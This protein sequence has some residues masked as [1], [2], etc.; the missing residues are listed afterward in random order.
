MVDTTDTTDDSAASTTAGSGGR[1]RGRPRDPEVERCILSAAADVFTDGGFEKFSVEA[2]AT[3]AG[4]AKASIYRRY[5][6]R[7]DLIVAMCQECTPSAA[8]PI[9]NGDLRSDLVEFLEFLRE[10]LS[11]T[12]QSGRLMPALLSAAKEYTE[13]RE[14]A[15]KFTASRRRRIHDI[16]KRAKA[17]GEL[18]AG[19]DADLIG[20]IIVGSILYRIVIRDGA[21]DR[22]FVN[23]VVDGI[24]DGF[25]TG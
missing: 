4:V 10:T 3:R 8:P 7:V 11:S 12:S 6:S 18:R 13:V 2:V 5:P 17:R 15:S 14:A 20:D 9:D 1:P 25:G 23:G 22:K 24:V 21:A 16:V 19:A